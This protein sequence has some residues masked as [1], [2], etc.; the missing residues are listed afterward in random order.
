MANDKLKE[1]DKNL[2]STIKYMIENKEKS[3]I[4]P[5]L[6][7]SLG[8]KIPKWKI[9]LLSYIQIWNRSHSKDLIEVPSPDKIDGKQILE[10]VAELEKKF[11]K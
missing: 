2:L 5:Q 7:R 9:E 4:S 10:R 11:A 8:G 1:V 6:E 3:R